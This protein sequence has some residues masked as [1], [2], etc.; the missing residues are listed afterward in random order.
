MEPYCA[1]S[2][3]SVKL[4]LPP[5]HPPAPEPAYRRGCGKLFLDHIPQRS[6]GSDFDMPRPAQ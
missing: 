2:L 1:L 4:N 3:S 5:R 6:D